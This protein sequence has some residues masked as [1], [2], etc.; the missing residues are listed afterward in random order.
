MNMQSIMA[1]AQRM[2]RDIQKKKDEI[3]QKVACGCDGIEY[4][5]MDDFIKLGKDFLNNYDKEI[6]H[7][8]DINVFIKFSF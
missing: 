8:K 6:F 2:Q 5:L 3:N 4:N 7:T 1:Q